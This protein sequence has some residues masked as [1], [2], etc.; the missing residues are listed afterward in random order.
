[1]EEITNICFDSCSLINLLN[2]NKLNEVLNIPN[3]VFYLGH[4]AY[5]ELCKVDDQCLK[6]NKLLD[7]GSLLLY[8]DDIDVLRLEELFNLYGLGDGE[9]EAILICS[10]ENFKICCDDRL[11]RKMSVEEI[12]NGNV[13]GSLRLL[14]FAVIH[15]II[16]CT[17]AFASYIDMIYKGGFLPKNIGN[18]FFCIDE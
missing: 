4:S 11:A 18:H 17:D 8:K 13:M 10:K 9:T 12:G 2:C 5:D 16:E 15:N 7:S 1:M 3:Y 6:I 14:K